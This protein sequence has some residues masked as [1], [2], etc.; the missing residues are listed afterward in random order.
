VDKD[1]AS[2]VREVEEEIASSPDRGY[3]SVDRPDT[4][5]GIGSL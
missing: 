5:L 3:E 2:Y 4:S 1:P